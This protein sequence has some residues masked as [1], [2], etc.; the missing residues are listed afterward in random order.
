MQHF[1]II[2]KLQVRKNRE[3]AAKQHEKRDREYDGLIFFM[4]M[5]K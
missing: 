5:T 3:T 1:I 4:K 2:Y